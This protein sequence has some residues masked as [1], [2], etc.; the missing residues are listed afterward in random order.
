MFDYDDDEK[1][2]TGNNNKQKLG[3]KTTEKGKTKTIQMIS[4]TKQTRVN[5]KERSGPRQNWKQ[6]KKPTKFLN[7]TEYNSLF[8]FYF[9]C[10]ECCYIE[11][12]SDTH[13]KTS[14]TNENK[15]KKKKKREE[16]REIQGPFNTEHRTC[17]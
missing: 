12:S 2:L 8:S 15:P 5:E 9:L 14:H 7:G 17:D 11:R 4:R 10:F 6:K 1:Q 13:T 3:T 16:R